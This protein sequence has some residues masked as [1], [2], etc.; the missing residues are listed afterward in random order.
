MDYDRIK[1]SKTRNGRHI[2][3]WIYIRIPTLIL[4]MDVSRG[5]HKFGGSKKLNSVG[6]PNDKP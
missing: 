6:V 1:S 5:P 2:C 3:S 4:A